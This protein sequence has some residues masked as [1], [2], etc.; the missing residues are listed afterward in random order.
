MLSIVARLILVSSAYFIWQERNNRVHV[1]PS[2]NE[3][4][5]AKIIVE[6]VRSNLASIRFKNE[7][8]IS[9]IKATW[10]IA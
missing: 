8:R 5:V 4:Q 1:K 3:D 10:K 2:R 6:I 9:Q 7:A